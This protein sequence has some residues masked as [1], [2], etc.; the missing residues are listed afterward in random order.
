MFFSICHPYLRH[1][2]SLTAFDVYTDPYIDWFRIKRSN[3]MFTIPDTG[4]NFKPYF[5]PGP[6]RGCSPRAGFNRSVPPDAPGARKKILPYL[7]PVGLIEQ[8]VAGVLIKAQGNIPAPAS[9]NRL[10][11]FLTPLSFSPTGSRSPESRRRGMS[12]RI[13]PSRS[14]RWSMRITRKN[15]GRPRQ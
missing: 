10:Y 9:E 4:W 13:L 6:R 2:N 5:G 15:P 12:V 7:L 14:A 1:G 3:L 11:T 8:L